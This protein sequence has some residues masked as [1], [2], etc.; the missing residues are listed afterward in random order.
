MVLSQLRAQ[1][2]NT[3]PTRP[4]RTRSTHL[5]ELSAIVKFNAVWLCKNE[6][7]SAASS[8]VSASQ[9]FDLGASVTGASADQ[10]EPVKLVLSFFA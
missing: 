6:M 7:T 8:F 5:V 9:T 3:L 2:V 4:T 10:P 1:R